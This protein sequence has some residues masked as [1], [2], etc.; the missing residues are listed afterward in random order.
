M[1]TIVIDMG[2]YYKGSMNPS[3]ELRQDDD[4]MI[5][6]ISSYGEEMAIAYS[7]ESLMRFLS[8]LIN[9]EYA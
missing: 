2:Y 1:K 4:D 7:G 9:D 5:H 3:I 8:G 6:C